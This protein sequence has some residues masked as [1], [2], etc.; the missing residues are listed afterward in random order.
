M[1]LLPHEASQTLDAKCLG[2]NI[3]PDFRCVSWHL[4]TCDRI[5][6]VPHKHQ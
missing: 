2:S 5:V 3:I 1:S 6:A 4:E